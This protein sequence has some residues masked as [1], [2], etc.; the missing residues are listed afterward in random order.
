MELTGPQVFTVA[1]LYGTS[2]GALVV[3]AILWFA[4]RLPTWLTIYY[5]GAFVLCTAGWEM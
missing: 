1:L 2:F 5:L 4:G 3:L